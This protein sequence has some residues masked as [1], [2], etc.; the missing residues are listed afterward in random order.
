MN[1]TIISW[2]VRGLNDGSKRLQVRNLLHSWKAD[3][4]CLQETKLAGVTPAL[5]RSL[6][7][8]KIVD[9]VCLDAIG[10]S[11]GIILLWDNRAVEKWRKQWVHFPFLANSGRCPLVL[12]GHSLVFMAPTGERRGGCYGRNSLELAHGGAF[13]GVWV[14]TLM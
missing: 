2:N 1:T 9:W 13:L 7:R 6:W 5:I 12:N 11:G 8:G 14:E 3:I 4:V 10:A